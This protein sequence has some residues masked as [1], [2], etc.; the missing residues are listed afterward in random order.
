MQDPELLQAT[1]SEPLTIQ[2]E[3]QMQC[4]WRNDR[5][6][7]TFI[8]L[9]REACLF[10][11]TPSGGCGENQGA[12]HEA[13]TTSFPSSM[14]PYPK[15]DG[16]VDRNIHAMAGDVNLFLS[17]E[18]HEGNDGDDDIDKDDDRK[19]DCRSLQAE[20]D[21]MIAEGK[22][23]NH[24]LGREACTLML[25]YG[26]QRLG[27]RRFFCK[28]GESNEASLR[29]FSALGFKQCGY[30]A[31]FHEFELELRC[32]TGQQVIQASTTKSGDAIDAELHTFSSQSLLVG[33]DS[34]SKAGSCQ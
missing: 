3:F 28:V 31:C 15:D 2:Q 8:V 13:H 27:I 16:F 29:L 30:A 32:E 10:L 12:P 20:I 22:Y 18:D 17:S 5:N 7:C 11:C 25:I 9:A 26:V 19:L 21:I 23:R 1:A 4:S 34:H 6:K 24:G 14:S 33:V